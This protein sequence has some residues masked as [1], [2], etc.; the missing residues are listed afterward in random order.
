MSVGQESKWSS[1]WVEGILNEIF[2]TRIYMS[3]DSDILKQAN[4]RK[5]VFRSNIHVYVYGIDYSVNK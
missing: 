4:Q 2:Q 1:V 5:T 3:Q